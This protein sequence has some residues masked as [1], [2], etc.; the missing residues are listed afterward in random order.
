MQ[1]TMPAEP[2]L[3]LKAG[4]T[5]PIEA[6]KLLWQ[7]EA[8]GYRVQL[9]CDELVVSPGSR[10]TARQRFDIRRHKRNLIALVQSEVV[11]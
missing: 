8:D 10:L 6:L 9:D 7:L 4:F 2:T 3:I 1:P 11:A 5:A